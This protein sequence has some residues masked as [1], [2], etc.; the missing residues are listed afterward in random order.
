MLLACCCSVLLHGR[1]PRACGLGKFLPECFLACIT[2]RGCKHKGADYWLKSEKPCSTC[3]A[4]TNFGSIARRPR[5]SYVR[6][7]SN[8]TVVG[9]LASKNKRRSVNLAVFQDDHQRLLYS[10]VP[11]ESVSIAPFISTFLALS[12]V[13]PLCPCP[14][15]TTKYLH[16][17]SGQWGKRGDGNWGM[18]RAGTCRSCEI[19]IVLF[20]IWD[21]ELTSG[22]PALVTRVW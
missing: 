5:W 4:V 16:C 11:L 10:D 19:G 8:T 1:R 12:T 18:S 6:I 3:I 9:Y 14:V 15:M 13:T 20:R 7:H 22:G 17:E 2:V 21:I